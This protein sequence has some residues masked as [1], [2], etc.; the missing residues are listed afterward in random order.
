MVVC[1]QAGAPHDLS[2]PLSVTKQKYTGKN[3]LINLIETGFVLLFT[4]LRTRFR[5]DV[6]FISQKERKFMTNSN[7][8]KTEMINFCCDKN[9]P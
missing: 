8:E 1:V 4:D 3:K 2:L 9:K 5:H 6:T 7:E